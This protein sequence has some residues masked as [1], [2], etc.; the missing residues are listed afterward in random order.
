MGWEARKNPM[1]ANDGRPWLGIFVEKNGAI[2]VNG[3]IEDKEMSLGLLKYAKLLIEQHHK[4]K[5]SSVKNR[6]MDFLRSK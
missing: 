1:M 2:K 5:Q 6:I 4:S 3:F